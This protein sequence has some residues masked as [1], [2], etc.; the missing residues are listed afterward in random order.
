MSRAMKFETVRD[1]AAALPA[2]F[3]DAVV[4]D[5]LLSIR[6]GGKPSRGEALRLLARVETRLAPLAA[7]AEADD[8]DARRELQHLGCAQRAIMIAAGIFVTPGAIAAQHED[9]AEILGA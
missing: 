6:S 1:L 9:A 3:D 2:L 5:V 7:K 8:E 4:G